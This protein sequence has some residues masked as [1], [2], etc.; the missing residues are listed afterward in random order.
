MVVPTI[1]VWVVK[2]IGDES[3]CGGHGSRTQRGGQFE[4]RVTDRRAPSAR[5][6]PFTTR[7]L[8]IFYFYYLATAMSTLHYSG[9][10]HF[11]H[12]LVLSVLSGKALKIEKIRPGD[13][14]PGLRG[15]LFQSVG[16]GAYTRY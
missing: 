6:P 15:M 1:P 11:R 3:V 7:S 14:N 5:D 13:N 2:A 16:Y 10:L 4:M 12:R 8:R 9:H